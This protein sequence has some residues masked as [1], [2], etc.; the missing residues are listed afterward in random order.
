MAA[1]PLRSGKLRDNEHG[2]GWRAKL[3]APSPRYR[4]PRVKFK[5]PATK[6]WVDRPVPLGEDPD[7]HFDAIERALDRCVAQT[8]ISSGTRPTIGDLDD[9]YIEWLRTKDSDESYVIK[10]ENV[11]DK[12]IP[13]K[14][15][16]ILVRD[17]S[18]EHSMRWIGNARKAGLSAARVED[19]GV[20]LSGMRKTARRKGE[21][22]TRWMDPSE[23][24]LEDVKYSRRAT[25]QGGD[26]D[27]IPPSARPLTDHV[28]SL[29]NEARKASRWDWQPV[30]YEI[31]SYCAH[32]MGA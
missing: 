25:E 21:D 26:R 14:D 13:E 2:R 12:W 22:G 17:W 19:L 10:V 20:A 3:Y 18:P 29:I 1:G 5:D 9:R 32:E 8:A 11:L 24:P 4:Y 28:E 30:A 7:E 6:Q 27:W 31:G 23:D 15:R 16:K